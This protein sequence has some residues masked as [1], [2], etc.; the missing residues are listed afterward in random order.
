MNEIKPRFRGDEYW[1]FDL[2]FSGRDLSFEAI[3]KIKAQEENLRFSSSFQEESINS[4]V[5]L[6]LLSAIV[7]SVICIAQ[8][9]FS[10]KVK[11]TSEKQN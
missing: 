9:F 3:K 2:P 4:K 7:L 1:S 11:N 5:T 6:V 10:G 8:A